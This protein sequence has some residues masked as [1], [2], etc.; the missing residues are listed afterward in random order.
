LVAQLPALQA[1]CQPMLKQ[2]TIVAGTDADAD[3]DLDASVG[4]GGGQLVLLN[5]SR[6]CVSNNGGFLLKYQL[7]DC[8]SD[9][10]GP[11]TREY[12][13][14]QSMC[15]DV[16]TALPGVKI[17]DVIRVRPL[18]VAGVHTL[19]D[20]ALRYAPGTNAVS[21]ECSGTTLDYHCTLI[22][23]APINPATA[24]QANHLC[25]INHAGFVA[26]VQV[27]SSRTGKSVVSG[28]FPIDETRCVNLV[29]DVG[30]SAH[31]GDMFSA[32]VSAVWGK[33]EGVNR[34]VEYAP[35]N[36][37]ATFECKG[38]TLDFHCD[39]LGTR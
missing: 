14:D 15:V 21:F 2:R 13:I 35:N 5:V 23:V 26:S 4:G 18:A 17:G 19:T 38:T 31:V 36:L 7:N 30:G 22:S 37:T 10:S 6:V 11:L 3:A 39:L 16:S 12:P 20:P 33:T 32:S 25:V 1:Q 34:Q 29:S 27:K 9:L 8:P 24:P 28:H